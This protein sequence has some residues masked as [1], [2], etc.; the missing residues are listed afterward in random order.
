MAANSITT[1]LLLTI[2]GIGMW[3]GLGELEKVEKYAIALNLGMIAALLAGLGI[4]NFQLA[5]GGVW[6]LPPISSSINFH[7]LRVLLGL[8]NCCTGF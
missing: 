7:D 5:A 1:V 6:Q 3:R 2:G 4:Y 8:F